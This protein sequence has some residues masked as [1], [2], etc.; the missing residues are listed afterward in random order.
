M[1]IIKS[2]QVS[3]KAK[4]ANLGPVCWRLLNTL[5]EKKEVDR[6][7]EVLQIFEE[8]KIME[9]SNVLLGPLMKAHLAEYAPS[10]FWSVERKH[11]KAKMTR[12]EPNLR[13]TRSRARAD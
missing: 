3:D 12:L 8:R 11:S 10:I 9:I 7:R 5:A 2:F 1:D 6:I 4:D 13:P